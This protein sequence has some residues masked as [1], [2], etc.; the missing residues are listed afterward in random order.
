MVML[1]GLTKNYSLRE[2]VC[3]RSGESPPSKG[4]LGGVWQ[5][6]L[7]AVGHAGRDSASVPQPSLVALSTYALQRA[8]PPKRTTSLTRAHRAV[9]QKIIFFSNMY[10]CFIGVR[11]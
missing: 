9:L 3:P 7:N 4:D 6:E 11:M 8:E 5:C 2:R 1:L 10:G